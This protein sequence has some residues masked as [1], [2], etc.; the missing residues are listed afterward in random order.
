MKA[1]K[2]DT[3]SF[4]YLLIMIHTTAALLYYRL[5]IVLVLDR[6]QH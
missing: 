3:Q 6:K 4:N 2:G 1:S 5:L